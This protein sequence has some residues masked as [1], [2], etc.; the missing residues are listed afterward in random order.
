MNNTMT[1]LRNVLI[2]Y[3]FG[4]SQ[5]KAR[6]SPIAICGFFF[7]FPQCS[8]EFY[9]LKIELH[10]SSISDEQKKIIIEKL[11]KSAEDWPKIV[12]EFIQELDLSVNGQNEAEQDF[13][14]DLLPPGLRTTNS[15][16]GINDELHKYHKFSGYEY[17][18]CK[19]KKIIIFI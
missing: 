3:L 2:E 7:Y 19:L 14:F 15:S 10:S 17:N 9:K 16:T 13:D 8:F 4:T 5:I 6:S 18:K 12:T 1:L 11:D